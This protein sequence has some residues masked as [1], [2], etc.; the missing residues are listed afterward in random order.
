MVLID[1]QFTSL[2]C[3]RCNH[4]NKKNR[5]RNNRF[6]CQSCGYENS[7]DNVVASYNIAQRF[8][9]NNVTGKK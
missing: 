1:E 7:N 5:T 3:P 6:H 4:T 8:W 2:I 9:E